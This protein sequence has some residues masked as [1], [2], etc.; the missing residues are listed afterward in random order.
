M[1]ADLGSRI[2]EG[3][4]AEVFRRPDGTVLKLWRDKDPTGAALREATALEVLPPDLGPTLIRRLEWEGRPGLIMSHVPGSGLAGVLRHQP[5]RLDRVAAVLAHTHATIH[6]IPAPDGLPDVKQHL[7]ARIEGADLEPN[8]KSNAMRLLASLPGGDR[9]CHGDF[10]VGNVLGSLDRPS[11]I[12]WP[13]ACSGDPDA[14]VAQTNILHRFARP[15]EGVTGLERLAVGIG[16]RAFARRYI[17]R[18]Q[19]LRALDTSAVAAWETV[20]AAARLG[21]GVTGERRELLDYLMRSEL[22][23]PDAASDEPPPR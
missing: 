17:R 9:L 6:S 10:H 21:L 20:C 15:R 7:G 19:S 2:G 8:L 13:S 4:Q 5:W 22:A 11:V 3:A 18:Y 12:D 14:D 23:G 16:R 1:E